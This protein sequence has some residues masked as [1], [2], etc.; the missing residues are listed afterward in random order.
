M[1]LIIGLSAGILL[2]WF[3]ASHRKPSGTFII[4]FSDIDKDLCTLEL[5]KTLNE[6]YSKKGMFV[7][8]KTIPY[9]SQK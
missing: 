8:I 1:E 4:D 9:N 2:G 3:I 6:L 7:R 5:D